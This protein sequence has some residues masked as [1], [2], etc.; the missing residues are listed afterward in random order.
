MQTLEP[1][2]EVARM[3]EAGGAGFGQCLPPQSIMAQAGNALGRELRQSAEFGFG[4]GEN[5]FGLVQVIEFLQRTAEMESR[6]R[7]LRVMRGDVLRQN[8]RAVTVT[9]EPQAVEGH[10]E[11]AQMPGVQ[12]ERAIEQGDGMFRLAEGLILGRHLDD[13]VGIVGRQR[14]GRRKAASARARSPARR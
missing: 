9:Q 12:I 4:L 3:G 8:K 1:Q 14:R 13:E 7:K 5:G 10:H 2:L 11:R 6:L